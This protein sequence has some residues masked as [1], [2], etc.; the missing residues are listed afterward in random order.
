MRRI[1]KR[2]LAA[3]LAC[4]CTAAF[5]LA[6]PPQMLAASSG[7]AQTTDYLNLRE[8]AGTNAKVILTLGKNVSLTILDDSDAQWAKVK[9]VNGKIGYCSKQYLSKSGGSGGIATPSPSSSGGGKGAK[10]TVTDS[11]RLR[12]SASA[13]GN[14]IT[15]MA[16]GTSVTV[17][18][19][20]N[21]QWVK[22][23]MPNGTQGWC[24]RSYLSIS[25][26]PSS[27]PASSGTATS[28]ATAK[29]TDFLKLREGASTSTK[30]ILTLSKGAL[31]F[32][33]DNSNSQWVKVRTQSGQQ[34]WC[35][36]QYLNISG[37]TGSGT[38]SSSPASSSSSQPQSSSSSPAS[39]DTGGSGT[40]GGTTGSDAKTVTGATVTADVLRLRESAGSSA[41]ILANLTQ[42]TSLT[43]LESPSSGWVKVKTPDG[44]TG[45]VSGDYVQLQYS[46]G[47]SSGG[48]S[49]G[50]NASGLTL[51]S[52][53]QSIPLGKTLYLKATTNPDGSGVAWSSN[54]SSVA[55]V[56]NGYVTATGKGSTVINATSGS[57][58]ATCSV[59]VTDAEPVRTAY[60]TPNVVAPGETVTLTAVTDTTRDGV[61]FVISMPGGGTR[62]VAASASQ[63]ENTGG[64]AVK[65][66][67]GTTTFSAAGSYS[68][69]AQSSVN[70]SFSS[71]GF[72]TS[73]YVA[74]QSDY[75]VS[76]SEGRRASDK[77]IQ[78]ISQWEGYRAAVY[79]DTLS[80]SQVP[81]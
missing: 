22:V 45:Y 55:T 25:G 3:V 11:L 66:W 76:T 69:L 26:S 43:V 14:I 38:A 17:L 53:S 48:Q 41:K 70:G 49:S 23:Q 64:V 58:K 39:S 80:S 40:D 34:G 7:T 8:N 42:G 24:S 15:V 13:S 52:N 72:T 54:N 20:S 59:T 36:R 51:S 67:T 1:K 19:N 6:Y 32:V 60:A 56:V 71:S 62:S 57:C 2:R 31:L 12:K 74:S 78:L 33:L 27:Q 9:T 63:Q 28:G 37:N 50:G 5:A 73:A 16:K 61:R 10:A 30:A 47:T 35:S 68:V 81:I 29:T 4:L 65:R 46:D 77:I 18:D 75:T 79:T 21:S 44:K